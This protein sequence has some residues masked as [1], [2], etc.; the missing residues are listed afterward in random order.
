MASQKRVDGKTPAG[1]A[2]SI[3][4][5]LDDQRGAVDEKQATKV[6]IVEFTKA[7]EEIKRTYGTIDREK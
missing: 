5:F 6:E 1:G 2:Y 4:Y 7:G 3:A